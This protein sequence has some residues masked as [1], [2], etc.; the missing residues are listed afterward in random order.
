MI[1]IIV[2]MIIMTILSW[3]GLQSCGGGTAEERNSRTHLQVEW[4]PPSPSQPSY[5]S[6]AK[7]CPILGADLLQTVGSV[8]TEAACHSLCRVRAWCWCWC[9]WLSF[10]CWLRCWCKLKWLFIFSEKIYEIFCSSEVTAAITLGTT[11]PLLWLAFA[12]SSQSVVAKM[13]A[14]VLFK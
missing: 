11:Q 13:L 10:W 7:S 9:W 1:I 14:K 12:S 5:P 3:S 2:T 4:F 8:A 6:E